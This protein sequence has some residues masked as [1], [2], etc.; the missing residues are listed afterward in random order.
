MVFKGRSKYSRQAEE[1]NSP[2]EIVQFITDFDGA[3]Y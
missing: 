1:D 2:F 3:L